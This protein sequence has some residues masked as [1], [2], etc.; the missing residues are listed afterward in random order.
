[1]PEAWGTGKMGNYLMGVVSLLQDRV[2][3]MVLIVAQH[4]DCNTPEPYTKNG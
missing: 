4:Y 3:E 2:L 1:M